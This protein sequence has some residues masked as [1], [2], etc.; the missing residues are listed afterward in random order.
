MAVSLSEQENLGLLRGLEAMPPRGLAGCAAATAPPPPLFRF[1]TPRQLIDWRALH[2]LDLA[3]VVRDTDIDALESVLDI[4]AHGDMEGEDPRC[5]T[6]ANAARAFRVAQLAVDYLLHVQDR[7]A[8]DACSAKTELGKVQ[9]REQLLQLK[10]KELREELAGSRKEVRHLKKAA[11]TL[12]ALALARQAA[13]P[14]PP[15]QRVVERVV[16]VPDAA[17]ARRAE[18]LEAEL[19]QLEAERLELQRDNR[20]LTGE[21]EVAQQGAAAVAESARREER[22]AAQQR[23]QTAVEEERRR[24]G[25]AKFSVV[26]SGEESPTHQGRLAA[27]L[28][29]AEAAEAE[30]PRAAAAAGKAAAAPAAEVRR[31]RAALEASQAEVDMLRSRLAAAERG[32]SSPSPSRSPSPSAV[33]SRRPGRGLGSELEDAADEARLQQ[34]EAQV[35]EL[36]GQLAAADAVRTQLAS[37]YAQ[38]EQQQQ[39]QASAALPAAAAQMES[40]EAQAARLEAARLREEKAALKEECRRLRQ[41]AAEQAAE[42]EHLTQRLQ[43]LA[44]SRGGT[45]S[46][47][48]PASLQA[49]PGGGPVEQCGAAA[50]VAQAPARPIEGNKTAFRREMQHTLHTAERPGVVSRFPHSLGSFLALRGDLQGELEAELAEELASYGIDPGAQGLTGDQLAEAM[51]ELERRRAEARRNMSEADRQ[52]ADYMRSTVGWHVQRMAELASGQRVASP[53]KQAM[54][55]QPPISLKQI[56]AMLRSA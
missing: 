27:A 18:R 36:Q 29:R 40:V 53:V 25:K 17:A 9:R 30:L 46:R 2:A 8:G 39:Q 26:V 51:A 47:A 45:S 38:L 7:L 52:R 19:A 35:Q 54:L 1:S 20:K 37:Q 12:E 3:A 55:A 15:E 43:Q 56:T 13:P 24:Q 11:K 16:E 41:E 50:A 34:L 10:V 44:G 4:V 33:P 48:K 6:P 49:A 5:L 31:L 23:L 22:E 28:R 21:L 42:I 14:P 32:R